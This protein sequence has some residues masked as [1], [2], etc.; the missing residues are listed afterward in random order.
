MVEHGEREEILTTHTYSHEMLFVMDDPSK[1]AKAG[2]HRTAN[3]GSYHN[4]SGPAR[5][6]RM[7]LQQ[8]TCQY[9]G[10]SRTART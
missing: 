8:L 1:R 6:Q 9:D 5:K 7:I 10:Q 2:P 3:P 4:I